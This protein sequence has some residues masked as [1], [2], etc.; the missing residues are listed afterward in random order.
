[1]EAVS[2]LLLAVLSPLLGGLMTLALPRRAILPRVLLALAGMA[3]A[4]ALVLWHAASTGVPEAPGAA[5]TGVLAWMPSLNVNFAWLTD[6]LGVF[7]GLLVAGIGMM[8]VLYARGYFGP[9]EDEL[10]R[11]YP[12]LGFFASAMIGVVLADY[13]LLTLLFWELTSISSF[14]LIGWDRYDRKAVKL[15][16]QA[17][18]TTGLGGMALFGGLLL[19]GETSGVWR[20]SELLALSEGEVTALATEPWTVWAFVMI[21]AGAATK[22]AQFPFHYWLPGAMAA[23]TPV[24]AYLHSATMVKAGVYLIGRVFPVLA[25]LELWGWIIIPLGAITMLYGA[26]LAVNQHDLKRIFAYTTVSQLGLLVCMYGLGAIEFTAHGHACPAIDWDISQIANH[27]FYKAPLFI[28]AGAIGHVAGTRMLP[29]LF[30]WGR[31]TGWQN[32]TMVAVLLLAA[33]A[34]AA[35]PGTIS[36]PGKELFL[37]AIYH[38][39]EDVHP[40]F[41]VIMG[42]A[43]LTAM[44]NMAIFLRLA[45]TLLGLPGGLRSPRA[46]EL[47]YEAEEENHGH[48]IEEH[49]HEHGFWGMMLWVPALVL[50]LPQYVG[51]IWTPAWNAVFSEVEIHRY[52]EGFREGLPALW[53]LHLSLP[54]AMSALAALLGVG[55]AFAPI[56]RRQIVDVFDQ[57]YP[58]TYW[59]AVHGGG[60]AFRVV[61]TGHLRHYLLFVIVAT[62]AM[63]AGAV[64][65]EPAMVDAAW[66]GLGT[67]FEF[68]PGMLMGIIVCAT[69]VVLPIARTRVLR[70]LL[71]GS[72]GFSVVGMYL[73]YQAPDLALTQVM[74]ELIGVILFVL[75]LRLLPERKAPRV[76]GRVWRLA[77]SIAV[78][79]AFGW[80]TL[81]AATADRPGEHEVL[82][83]W[84]ARHSYHGTAATDERGGGGQNIVNVI[85][86]DFRGFDTLGE[87]TVLGLAA[88]GVW[89]L[90][91]GRWRRRQ[92]L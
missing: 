83:S 82:G 9:D 49:H 31:Q 35:L 74:V 71:L 44:C 2:I 69:A 34:L 10:R 38:L 64:V 89:S 85:L 80:M 84:F 81:L 12:T 90:F 41:W 29:E 58:A 24:S 51:G 42:M 11:F 55:L 18:F 28:V 73:V 40:V 53:E 86:V 30:G 22:S 62:L 33:Y 45:T 65:Y 46:V 76:P 48:E 19:L 17:F 70:V 1:M 66:S 15:A 61:Q 32:K 56:M 54:L 78:G 7:F 3:A 25:A 68:W 77:V 26:L 79:L 36:F 5:A 67:T 72:C 92:T 60:A 8:I 27:A 87:I 13:M 91:P 88:M 39:A 4:F 57:V 59:L 50:V 43:V 47:Q 14:L 21:L 20:W 37:Y 63:F 23:P 75:V 52:Y 6:G 16:M